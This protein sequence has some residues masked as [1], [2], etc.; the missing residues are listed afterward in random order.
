MNITWKGSP[1][2]QTR[3]QPIK[4]IVIHWFGV[5]TLESANNRFQNKSNQVSAHYGISKGR[6]WQWVKESQM[7]Y[8]AGN[9]STNNQTIGIEHDAT[10]AHNLSEEDYQLSAQLVREIAKRHNLKISNKTVIGHR[11]LKP[12]QCPGTIDIN[13]IIKL[14]TMENQTKVVRS[15]D[16]HTLYEC[17]PIAISFDEYKKQASV[18]GILIPESIP[19]SSTL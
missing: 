5:G 12:T 6:V 1:N 15:K 14:A 17:T 7:A 10:T 2:S 13:K 19:N 11:S 4:Q 8:H 16:G 9:F 18:Q 3:T